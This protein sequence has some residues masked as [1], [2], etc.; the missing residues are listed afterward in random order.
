MA[1][2]RIRSDPQS[3]QIARWISGCPGSLIVW[4]GLAHGA[5][6]EPRIA[7]VIG[8]GAYASVGGL[9]NPPADAALIAGALERQGFAVTLVPDADLAAM[10]QAVGDFGAALRAAGPEATGLFYYA[11]H[12]VQSFGRNYLL[13]VDVALSNAA[14]LEL[15]AVEADSVL[16]QMA[17]AKNRTNIVILDACRNNPFEN[18]LDLGD[19]GLAEMKAPTGTFL[20]Y[21]TEPG[22]VA[23]DGAGGN[24]PF[25]GALVVEMATPGLPIEQVFKQVRVKV[26]GETEGRQ[27]PWDT[28]SL[29]ADFVFVP[30]GSATP[31]AEE[32]LWA[33]VALA[34]D[35]VQ[36]MLFMQAYPKSVHGPDAQALLADVMQGEVGGSKTGAGSLAPAVVAAEPPAPAE[37]A[38]EVANAEAETLAG[39]IQAQGVTYSAP[40]VA[41][42]ADLIGKSIEQLILSSPQFAPIEGLPDAAWKDQPCGNCHQWTKQALCDQGQFYVKESIA[43]SVAKEHPL[44]GGFRLVLRAWAEGGCN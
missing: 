2:V 34:R 24:S 43:R 44:G 12:G 30:S 21:A 19:N 6:A 33:Q 8:N 7:L 37:P 42:P 17:S 27:T 3:R 13:P 9:P 18:V 28:S 4:F 40:L 31:E 22:A 1:R 26:L 41:G 29:T 38:G 25:T 15:V 32:A 5:L 10:R 11:G 39:E 20:A 35:A 14:D 23:L 16:R 36:I